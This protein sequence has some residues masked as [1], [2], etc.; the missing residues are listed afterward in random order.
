MPLLEQQTYNTVAKYQSRTCTATFNSP[1]KPG[2]TIIIVASCA[3]TIPSTVTLNGLSGFTKICDAGSRDL[4]QLVW[5]RQG[6]PSISSVQVTAQDDNKSIQLRAYEWSGMSQTGGPDKLLVQVSPGGFDGGSDSV[7]TGTTGTTA[8]AD[9]LVMC[10]VTNQYA[11]TTQSG[12]TGSLVK[13]NES[14]S[15]Q[16][17]FFVF[18]NED[19]ERSRMTAHQAVTTSTGSFSL[20]ANLSSARRWVACLVTFKG[21]SSGPAKFS[22]TTQDPVVRTGGRGSLS[23]FGPLVS[24]GPAVVTGGR[25]VVAPFNYQY[26]LGGPT[27]L[28]IGSGTQFFVESTEGLDGWDVRTSDDDLPRGDG[29]IRGVDLESARQIVFHMNVGSGRDEVERNV[30]ILRRALVPRRED[31]FDMIWRVPTAP[32]KLMRVRAISLPRVRSNTDLSAAPV[33]FTLRAADPRQYSASTHRV[34]IP[35]T[36]TS[37]GTPVLTQVTNLGNAAAYPVITVTGPSS[38]P[39]VTRIELVNQ[40]GLVTFDVQLTLLKGA[41]LVGDMDA[42]ITGAP[43]SVVTLD[44]QSK[45]NSW[46]LPRDPFRI[47]PDPAGQGGFNNLY[48]RTTPPNAPV[49]CVVEYRDTSA[50]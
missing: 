26:R 30:E 32:V 28:L 3:G 27:G 19:W 46:Q 22:S 9:E 47:E 38:G 39:A 50:G 16:N 5:Y 10:F 48:L 8:Q 12:F 15:P 17:F 14:V 34:T 44:G 13:I 25:G 31:D 42:R 21:A 18:S 11:P 29:A 20:N 45:Y 37:G 35:V 36:P 41:V 7:F 2:S 49:T 40:S 4:Q 33:N 6:S 1:T 43:R 24:H 23:L